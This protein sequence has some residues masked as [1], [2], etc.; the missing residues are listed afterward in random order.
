MLS[1]K[2]LIKEEGLHIK[3]LSDDVLTWLM[4][5]ELNCAHD[6]GGVSCGR[7]LAS[8]FLQIPLGYFH[9]ICKGEPVEGLS[10]CLK[11]EAE[12]RGKSPRQL[13]L[14]D[15][16]TLE[17]MT[18]RQLVELAIDHM[19]KWYKADRLRYDCVNQDECKLAMAIVD[20]L[21]LSIISP[22]HSIRELRVTWDDRYHVIKRSYEDLSYYEALDK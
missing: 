20:R 19:A 17:Q 6:R 13:V 18:D 1:M 14:F 12:R 10:I 3:E 5:L 21:P 7:G 15:N 2:I 16:L 22:E 9:C 8:Y 11:Q 4:I